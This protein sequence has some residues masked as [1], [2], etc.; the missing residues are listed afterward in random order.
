[1]GIGRREF[2]RLTSL[3]LSG[4][5]VNPLQAVVTNDNIYV[6][7]K[8]GILFS[9]PNTW[10]FLNVKDFG[11]LKDQQVLG[12]GY[13]EIKD[14]V[15]EELGDPICIATKYY[16]DTPE[17]KGVFSPTLTLNITPKVEMEELGFADFE[18]VI[19]MSEL[20]TSNLLKDFKVIERYE[21]YKICGCNF[22]EI[23]SEYLFEHIEL[24][25]PLKVELKSLKAEHN[26]FYY[27]FNFHQSSAQNQI[28]PAEFE[29][30]KKSILLI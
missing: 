17:N 13:E 11:K 23:D 27:D 7:K 19:E 8:L 26:G 9:K 2:I 22:H 30:F 6:N 5:G 10:G 20:G 29:E 25:K 28:A 4:F 12:N 18:E 14:E 21:P 24:I 1:M 3:A 16:I 15:W